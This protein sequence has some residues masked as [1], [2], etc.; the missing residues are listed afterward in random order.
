[1]TIDQFETLI[2]RSQD[3]GDSQKHW[4]FVSLIYDLISSRNPDVS[5][6]IGTRPNAVQRL[7][8]AARDF[9]EVDLDA[10]LQ[11]TEDGRKTRW[12]FQQFA[13]D[14]FR[15][16]ISASMHPFRDEITAS[17]ESIKYVFGSSPSY[18]E[19]AG[20]CASKKADRV[21]RVDESWPV[22]IRMA[23]ESLAEVDAVAGK[24][25]EAWVRQQLARKAP[26]DVTDWLQESS[27][28]WESKLKRWWKKER[29]PQAALQIAASNSQRLPYFGETDMLSLAGENILVFIGIC[30]EIWECDA[31][32]RA[33]SKKPV[34][35]EGFAPFDRLRQ[36]EGI[37]DA[38]RLW[39]EKI[40]QSP[41][42]DTLQRFIDVIGQKLN[43]QLIEDRAMS[44][45]GANGISLAI[46]D[47]KNAPEIERLLNDATAECFLL[48]RKHTPK[49]KSLGRSAKWYPHPI[50]ASFYG[51]TIPHTK[52]PLYLKVETLRRWLEVGDV[53]ATKPESAPSSDRTVKNSGRKAQGDRQS[54]EAV[55][56]SPSS[57]KSNLKDKQMRLFGEED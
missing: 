27:R 15:R 20:L 30:K 51:L 3:D 7:S 14:A 10:I 36:S 26:V 40:A 5:Y 13:E 37:R 42:G 39:H 16:R 35:D 8:D 31:R 1:V 12:P 41:D 28:P 57:P 52:E 34:S 43:S 19:R 21:V 17:S 45:P 47:L 6:R 53:L 38:S 44:Y 4:R 18:A 56:G 2:R 54:D 9:S 22:D 11:R 29:L 46:D 33:A 55:K 48:R 49:K 32:H 25:G 50:L 23:V 24:L